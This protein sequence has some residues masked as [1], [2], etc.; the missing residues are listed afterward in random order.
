MLFTESKDLVN[1]NIFGSD[2]GTLMADFN[3]E[4]AMKIEIVVTL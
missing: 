1:I 2:K 4:T 3:M